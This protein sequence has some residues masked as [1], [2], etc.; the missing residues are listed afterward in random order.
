MCYQVLLYL[1]L[2]AQGQGGSAV[3]LLVP[4]LLGGLYAA[5]AGLGAVS[6]YRTVA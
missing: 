6:I 5:A 3:A 4:A 1:I 2:A